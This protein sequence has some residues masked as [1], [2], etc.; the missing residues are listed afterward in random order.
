MDSTD[1][2]AVL[3]K[4]RRQAREENIRITQHAQQ[5][6]AEEDITLDQVLEAVVAGPDTGELSRAS[7]RG[8]LPALWLYTEWASNTHCVHDSSA[9][10]HHH[11]RLP[12]YPPKW[13]T[14]T[15]RRN[16]T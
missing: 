7:Q 5:E 3:E 15:R 14:P 4:I 1:L 12:T 16:A 9:T 6:M 13:V 2:T 11:Y 8:L 10:A